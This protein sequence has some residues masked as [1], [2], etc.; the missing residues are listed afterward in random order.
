[1]VQIII[2]LLGY[3]CGLRSREALKLRKKDVHGS[4]HPELLVRVSKYAYL[5]SS[6]SVRRI[7]LYILFT[8]PELEFFKSGYP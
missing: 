8:G 2:T 6:D 1:M 3:R 5:K 7:P 4:E